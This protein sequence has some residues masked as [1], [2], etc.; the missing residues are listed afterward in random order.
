MRGSHI[1]F[2]R[3]GFGLAG[4]GLHWAG[5]VWVV[6]VTARHDSFH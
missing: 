5:E 6:A 1:W 2:Q 4:G 3:G